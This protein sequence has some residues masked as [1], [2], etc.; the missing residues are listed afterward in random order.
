VAIRRSLTGDK[1]P[2]TVVDQHPLE[3]FGGYAM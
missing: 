2:F 1:G 3:K